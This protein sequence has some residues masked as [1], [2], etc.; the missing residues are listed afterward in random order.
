MIQILSGAAAI[1]EHIKNKQQVCLAPD[2]SGCAMAVVSELIAQQKSQLRLVGV[3]QLGLQGDMLIGA[4]CVESVDAAAVT[5]G[6]FGQ[7]PQFTKAIIEGVIEM[8][9]STCPAIH[10][11]LQAAEKGIPFMPLRGILGSDV[12]AHRPDWHVIENPF[13]CGSE[14]D[15]IVLV[16][17]ITPDVALIHAPVA[18]T[19]GNVWISVRRELM[20]MAHAAKT[21]LVT[22]EKIIDGDLLLDSDKAPGCI[23]SLYIDYLA[24]VPMG[25]K[26]LGLFDCYHADAAVIERYAQAAKTSTNFQATVAELRHV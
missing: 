26:P 3:P 12:L 4:G 24:E 2:Y 1:A 16:P 25:A 20:L 6:E 5:L 18:D 23:P 13:Y 7:A 9:D 17:A 15:P 14:K 19:L 21:T 10:A 8:R 11:G 22:V